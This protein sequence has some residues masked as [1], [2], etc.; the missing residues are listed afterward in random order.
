M[1]EFDVMVLHHTITGMQYSQTHPV[2]LGFFLLLEVSGFFPIFSRL[3]DGQWQ[4]MASMEETP[5]LGIPLKQD[6]APLQGVA[7]QK[8]AV[9]IDSGQCI[10]RSLV[11]NGD[12]DC[13]EDGADEDRCEE[14]K[15]VCDIDKTPLNSELTGAGFDI[16][17]GE[18]KGRV[19]HT[20]SFGGQCRKVFSGDRREYYRLSESVLAYN[21]QVKVQNDFSYEFFNSTWSYT[22]LVERYENA[23]RYKHTHRHTQN[24]NLQKSKQLMVIENSVEVAQF[25]NNRPDFL[26]L[27]EPFWKELF[28][29]PVVYEY[30]VYR[31]LIENFGTHFLHSGSLGGHYKVIFYMDT[32]KMKAEGVSITDLYKCTSSGWNIFI[33]KKKKEECTKLDELLLTSSGSSGNKIKGDPYIEGGSPAA[34]AGLSYLDLDNPSGNSRMYT[35]WAASVTDYPR[36]IKK[37]LTP[38]YELVKEVPCSSVKKHYLKQAIEEYMAENDPCRCQPCQNGGGRKSRSRICNNPSPRGGGKSCVGEQHESKACEDE[39]LQHL[40][41]IEP[42]CFDLS[43]NPTEFC[44]P[45]PLL[46]NG[47]VQNAEN[48]YPVGKTIVY[49]CKHGYSLVGDPVAKCRSNLQWQV[50]ERYCQETACLLPDLERGLQGEPWKPVYEIGERITLSCPHGMHLEG[51]RSILCEPSLKWSPDVKTIQCKRPANAADI[52]STAERGSPSL[53]IC[54]TDQRTKRN[55]PLTVC[56]MHALE[57]M[58]RKYSLTNVENCQVPQAAEIPCGSCRSWEKCNVPSNTCVCDEDGLCEEGGVQVCAEVSGSAARRTM[59]ECELADCL[60]LHER[61]SKIIRV[62]ENLQFDASTLHGCQHAMTDCPPP[63]CRLHLDAVRADLFFGALPVVR[64]AVDV[65]RAGYGILTPDE[66]VPEDHSC[67][68]MPSPQIPDV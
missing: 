24:E 4:F 50:G 55:T 58:G 7:Q 32:D 10:S 3:G 9:V 37:K 22:K 18:T 45:P 62:M 34:V 15:T 29:L 12:Q 67:T 43:I 17:T 53:D 13:E 52:A 38:L 40:R 16:I 56:K 65:V 26:S 8:M 2:V 41:L 66:E 5:A 44:S 33:V 46:E 57:C 39:E 36:I 31:R 54:A 61:K 64:S 21:F 30:N 27:A 60:M 6:H 48:S 51:A 1:N 28:N 23:D 47:F 25:I 59:T 42:H 68:V 35:V 19:I 11:C 14:R 63:P 20:K 49:A